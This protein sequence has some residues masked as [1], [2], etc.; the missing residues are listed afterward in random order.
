ME[1]NKKITKL[2]SIGSLLFLFLTTALIYGLVEC[3]YTRLINGVS[4]AFNDNPQCATFISP[5]MEIPIRL[6]FFILTTYFF[7]Q[8]IGKHTKLEFLFPVIPCI[9][10][11]CSFMNY[12]YCLASP[13]SPLPI[14]LMITFISS[15]VIITILFC[16]FLAF[17]QRKRVKK[18]NEM[19]L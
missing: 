14:A 2:I 4:A 10:L 5:L 11:I 7:I 19:K 18:E 12:H 9:F 3:N 8:L 16:V 15:T 6:L 1:K 13:A 17:L